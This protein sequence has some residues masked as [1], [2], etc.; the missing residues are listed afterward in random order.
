MDENSVTALA[1]DP[2]Q[3]WIAY[4]GEEGIL[5]IWNLVDNNLMHEFPSEDDTAIK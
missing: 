5:R 4:G 1:M 2:N 3:K